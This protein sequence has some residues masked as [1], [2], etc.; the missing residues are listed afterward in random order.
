MRDQRIDDVS[1]SAGICQSYAIYE[2]NAP[3]LANTTSTSHEPSALW[4]PQISNARER[5]QSEA[6]TQSQRRMAEMTDDDYDNLKKQHHDLQGQRGQVI[7]TRFALVGRRSELQHCISSIQREQTEFLVRVRSLTPADAEFQA[8][9]SSAINSIQRAQDSLSQQLEQTKN[10]E[11]Q[12]N[13]LEYGLGKEENAFFGRLS[14]ALPSIIKTAASHPP[15]A[16]ITGSEG[17]D[18]VKRTTLQAFHDK[19]S[20]VPILEERLAELEYTF[21][22]ERS[23]R[24][25]RANLGQPILPPDLEFY[26]QYHQDRELLQAELAQTRN[27]VSRLQSR[28]VQLGLIPPP[29]APPS[30][31]HDTAVASE[32]APRKARSWVHA[33]ESGKHLECSFFSEGHRMPQLPTPTL[34]KFANPRERIHRWIA[35]SQATAEAPEAQDSENSSISGHAQNES[36]SGA[37][38]GPRSERSWEEVDEE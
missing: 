29:P 12:L 35:E 14:A 23:Q 26:S 22:V 19:S 36:S 10:L 7:D 37:N 6:A 27:E 16:D 17:L 15:P 9:L 11:K 25:T 31:N 18:H 21:G 13:K 28:C 1:Q 38:N 2:R 33:S 20:D 30:I 5:L 8:A 34:P 24:E 32:Q 4:T 3:S